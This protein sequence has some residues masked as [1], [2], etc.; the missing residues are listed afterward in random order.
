VARYCT[1]IIGI[2]AG[3]VVYDGSAQ[4]SSRQLENIYGGATGETL[5]SDPEAGG[6]PF[7]FD[8]ELQHAFHQGVPI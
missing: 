3:N 8:P 5:A 7:L 1:R 2:R 4:I 6:Q